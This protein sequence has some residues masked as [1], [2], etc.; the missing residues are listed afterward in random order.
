MIQ[1]SEKA[2]KVFK[3][4]HAACVYL[5][6]KVGVP[7]QLIGHHEPLSEHGL[8]VVGVLYNGRGVGVAK[9]LLHF[10]LKCLD[11]SRHQLLIPEEGK[12]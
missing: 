11:H 1:L 12:R 10:T 3:H 2:E 9:H 4:F 8:V 7:V 5:A 6:D